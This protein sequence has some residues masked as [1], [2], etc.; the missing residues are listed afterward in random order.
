MPS[1][2]PVLLLPD[3][4][5]SADGGPPCSGSAV[6]VEGER[7]AD[8]GPPEKF[9]SREDVERIAL[10][11]ATLIPGL[12]D[13]HAHLVRPPSTETAWDDQVL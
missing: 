7:I 13:A 1:A 12:I 8:I 6:L 4:I 2:P 5:W 9:A 10:P 11:G 3:R